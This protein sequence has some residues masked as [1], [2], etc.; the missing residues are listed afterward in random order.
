MRGPGPGL[1]PGPPF[2]EGG[3]CIC[4]FLAAGR[5]ISDLQMC[6]RQILPSYSLRNFVQVFSVAWNED[7]CFEYFFTSSL[8]VVF[9]GLCQC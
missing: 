1:D 5:R 2:P 8:I 6:H 4:V 9:F 3:V 7:L